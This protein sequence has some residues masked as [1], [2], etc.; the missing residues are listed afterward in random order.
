MVPDLTVDELTEGSGARLP[1][2]LRCRI[3]FHDDGR[4]FRS[5]KHDRPVAD[6]L[7]L[8]HDPKQRIHQKVSARPPIPR[9]YR[10]AEFV[11]RD[12]LI[13]VAVGSEQLDGL[14]QTVPF[15]NRFGKTDSQRS[16]ARFE[17][18]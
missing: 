9:L 17:C 1:V 7:I 10:F 16:L 15:T 3:N 18:A 4:I 2:I 13:V 12:R 5:V 6:P 11:Q 8:P 14:V